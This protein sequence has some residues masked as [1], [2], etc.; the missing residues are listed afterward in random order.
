[1]K[2]F[3]VFLFF[4]VSKTILCQELKSPKMLIETSFGSNNETKMME[5]WLA[6]N[7]DTAFFITS[8]GVTP[9]GVK[10]DLINRPRF[11]WGIEFM[12]NRVTLYYFENSYLDIINEVKTPTIMEDFNKYKI[13]LRSSYLLDRKSVV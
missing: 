13:L 3:F 4:S 8:S 7:N 11:Q 1:M 9:I 6:K 12:Y 2:L 10:L 5:R